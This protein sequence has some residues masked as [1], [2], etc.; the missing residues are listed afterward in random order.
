VR[1]TDGIRKISKASRLVAGGVATVAAAAGLFA[2]NATP[3]FATTSW[4]ARPDGAAGVQA[5]GFINCEGGYCDISAAITDTRADGH[6]AGVQLKNTERPGSSSGV[7]TTYA[8]RYNKSGNGTSVVR[9]FY[10]AECNSAHTLY[11]RE[12]VSE[13]AIEDGG[14][15][16]DKGEWK[17]VC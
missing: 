13:G 14:Y 7:E 15:F 6:R 3:A 10:D 2:A 12:F 11:V 4:D 1:A 17:N 5:H 9:Y 16:V 8:Y